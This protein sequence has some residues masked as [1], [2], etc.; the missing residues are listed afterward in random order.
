MNVPPVDRTP[1]SLL[2]SSDAQASEASYIGAFNFRLGA[3]VYNLGLR[4]PDTTRFTFDTNL[5][6]TRV[7]DNPGQFPEAAGYR[8]T[9]NYCTAY[10][11]W[12]DPS[13]AD[14]DIWQAELITFSGTPTLTYFHPSCG[15]PVNE[16]LWLND[17]HPTYPMHNFLASQVA[18][19]L[20]A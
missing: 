16:Y 2:L 18:R 7:L 4:H 15:V 14:V 17:L 5:L 8:N 13:Y 11:K 19:L 9:T 10:M 1:M 6:F 3:L 20:G 12:V